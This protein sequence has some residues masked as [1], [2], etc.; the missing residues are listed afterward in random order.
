MTI[1][2]Q[3]LML[4]EDKLTPDEIREMHSRI[5]DLGPV[6]NKYKMYNIKKKEI[7]EFDEMIKGRDY[8]LNIDL[9]AIKSNV[10]EIFLM[11]KKLTKAYAEFLSAH[12]LPCLISLPYLC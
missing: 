2:E 10:I 12:H 4:S 11:T 3:K 6:V 8:I 1:A 9:F 5:T 7:I